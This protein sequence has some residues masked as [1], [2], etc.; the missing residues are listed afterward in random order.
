MTTYRKIHG[1]A[2]KS[3]SS[4]L[5]APSAEGQIWFNT[6]DNKFRSVVNLEAFTS[7]TPY[8][9]GRRSFGS[10][11]SQTANLIFGGA[12]SPG[13]Q[14]AT[15]EYNGSG[16]ANGGTFGSAGYGVRGM[17]TQTAALS[18]GLFPPGG[19]NSATYKY[20]GSSWTSAGALPAN[21]ATMGTAGTQ[22]AGLAFGGS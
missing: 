12:A 17:G 14:N 13:A 18:A 8:T 11:G 19:F 4:N 1:R 9:T 6:T 22:T 15:E 21:R 10:A 3:V 2:I 16:W 5:S 7:S 20:D